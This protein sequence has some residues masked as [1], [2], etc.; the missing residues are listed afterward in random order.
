MTASNV[1]PGARLIVRADEAL[2]FTTTPT[3]HMRFLLEGDASVP[4][5]YDERLMPGD[6]PPW[7][8]HPW[9]T[10]DTVIEGKVRF[11]IGDQT[12]DA[13]A[14][15]LVFSP[16]NVPHAFMGAGHGGSR[17]LGVNIP[18]GFHRLYAELAAA[19]DDSGA[20]DFVAMTEAAARHG[21]EILG[22]PLAILEQGEQR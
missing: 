10:W 13:E 8:R 11:R 3:D 7:H 22:P 9:A 1:P 18:G 4:D 14:G 17:I 5:I 19:F 12:I 16:P 20:A 2:S 15:D 21:A 6:G